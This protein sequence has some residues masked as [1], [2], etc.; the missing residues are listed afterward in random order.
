VHDRLRLP[1]VVPPGVRVGEPLS[2]AG[3]RVEQE[4]KRRELA[5]AHAAIEQSAE[6]PPVHVLERDVIRVVDPP[7]IEHPRDVRVLELGR[8]ARLVLEHLHE[9]F[10]LGDLRE[11]ALQRDDVVLGLVGRTEDL[12]HPPCADALE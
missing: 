3:E 8:D 12:G 11:N 6:I 7:E 5:H 4:R 2:D 10:V 9:L 1:V